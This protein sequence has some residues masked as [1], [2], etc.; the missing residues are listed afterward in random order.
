MPQ[1]RS[2]SIIKVHVRRRDISRRLLRGKESIKR[3]KLIRLHVEFHGA[4]RRT[5]SLIGIV[6]SFDGYPSG[7]RPAQRHESKARST[8]AKFVRGLID[9]SYPEKRRDKGGARGRKLI[10]ARFRTRPSQCASPPDRGPQIY[11]CA[12]PN[13]ISSRLHRPRVP[14]YV[15]PPLRQLIYLCSISFLPLPVL[16]PS[17]PTRPFP[18]TLPSAS[19]SNPLPGTLF[20]RIH[21]CSLCLLYRITATV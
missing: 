18:T 16:P 4:A 21:T 3:R 15:I 7:A 20:P 13:Q 14:S 1:R 9:S 12:Y 5:R 6:L 19:S 10:A 11:H 17:P 2:Q 8:V